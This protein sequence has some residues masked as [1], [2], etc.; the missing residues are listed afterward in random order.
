MGKLTQLLSIAL[1]LTMALT[2]VSCAGVV[3]AQGA[4]E[5]SVPSGW[6]QLVYNIRQA[7]NNGENIWY[8]IFY[9]LGAGF[10]VAGLYKFWEHK[11]NPTSN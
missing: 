4:S 7:V 11:Q 8:A 1:A 10:I 6:Q 5:P 9:V 2:V 3:R